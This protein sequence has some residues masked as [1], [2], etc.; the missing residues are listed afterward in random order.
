MRNK[1]KTFAKLPDQIRAAHR[2]VEECRKVTDDLSL[3]LRKAASSEL[4]RAVAVGE[5]LTT[6]R[7]IHRWYEK[8][9][10]SPDGVPLLPWDEWVKEKTGLSPRTERRYRR[11]AIPENAA[12]LKP[13]MAHS[14]DRH[15]YGRGYGTESLT[16]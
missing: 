14:G 13:L 2:E 7:K 16:W 11:Y 8:R 3:K 1:R 15:N 6:A 4:V 12:K 5:L 10:K 9:K